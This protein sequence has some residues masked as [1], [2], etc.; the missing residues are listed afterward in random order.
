MTLTVPFEDDFSDIIKKA[1]FGLGLSEAEVCAR[2]GITAAALRELEA[3]RLGP[4]E[5]ALRAIGKALGLGEGKLADVAFRPSP[6]GMNLPESLLRIGVQGGEAK[7]NAFCLKDPTTHATV[8]IDPASDCPLLTASG[9]LHSILLTHGHGDHVSGVSAA[10]LM[11]S[12]GAMA[13]RAEGPLLGDLGHRVGLVEPGFR[14][15]VG[16]L[17]IEFR[18]VPGHTAGMACLVVPKV[19]LAFTGDALFARS[20]GR[21]SAPG[22]PYHHQIE[23]VKRE[24]LSLPPATILCPG[25][26]PLT[27]VADELRLNPFFP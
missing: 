15:S 4:G 26:G 22:E 8:L 16:S 14:V 12:V 23:A 3:A 11:H 1:R 25:H 10:M 19:G 5:P 6:P 18:P 24:I 20:L 21:A 13:L 7:S 2:S 27:T 17:E 9:P